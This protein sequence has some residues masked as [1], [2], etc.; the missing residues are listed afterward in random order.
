MSTIEQSIAQFAKEH[1]I[2][3]TS[4]SSLVDFLVN[5]A[6]K[7]PELHTIMTTGTEQQREAAISAGVE[8]WFRQSTAF[9]QELLDNTTPRAK[10][11]REEIYRSLKD[12]TPIDPVAAG[13]TG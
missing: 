4:L 1:G 2:D 13:I 10:Q 12:G 8:N 11:Y 9:F 7:S 6:N 3:A 5:A